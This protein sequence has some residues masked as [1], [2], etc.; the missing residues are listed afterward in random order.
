M[1]PTPAFPA[2][3]RGEPGGLHDCGA[4]G[5]HQRPL[6]T[7]FSR[8]HSRGGIFSGSQALVMDGT[9]VAGGEHDHD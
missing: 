9:S 7:V 2:G 3:V 8:W 1:G 4:A 6:C 5:A